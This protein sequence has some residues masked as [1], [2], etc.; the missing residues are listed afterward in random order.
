MLA[1]K[2]PNSLVVYGLECGE[3][4]QSERVDCGW[5]NITQ[6]QCLQQDCCYDVTSSTRCYYLAGEAMILDYENERTEVIVFR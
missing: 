2:N 4:S 3:I 6:V 5:A 1:I